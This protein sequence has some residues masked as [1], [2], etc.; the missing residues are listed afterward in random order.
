MRAVQILLFPTMLLLLTAALAQTAATTPWQTVTTSDGSM[1]QARHES[2]AV[3]V[4]GKLY[5]L[6]GRAIRNIQEFDPATEVWT[7]L[8]P[9]PLELHHFQPVAIDQFIYVIA[10]FTCCYPM[11]TLVPEIHVFDTQTLTWSVEGSMPASR[12]RGSA[13]SVVRDGII[14]IVGGN[15]LGHSGGAVNWFDKYDPVTGEWTELPDAPNA[16]DHFAAVLVNDY[17]VAAAGRQTDLPNPFNY[18][19]LPTDVFDFITGEWHT[20]DPIPTPR[21]GVL[22]AAAGDE[23]LIAGGEINTSASALATVE[24]FNVYSGKWRTLEPLGIARHSGG[25]AVI[26]QQF[27]VLAGSMNAGGAPE[28]SAHE[29][30]EID[31]NQSIDFDADGLS[32]VAERAVYGTNP[33][34]ADTDFD[35]LSDQDEITEHGSDPLKS[36]TDDDG[37]ADGDEVNAWGTDPTD[38]DTDGDTLSDF[39][40]VFELSTN[41]MLADTDGDLLD[42]HIEINVH[43]T[44]PANTDTDADGIGDGQEVQS[45]LNPLDADSDNDGIPDGQDEEPLIGDAPTETETPTETEVPAETETPTETEV[46]T[47]TE[48]EPTPEVDIPI[49]SG[50]SSGGKVSILLLAALLVGR[51]SRIRLRRVNVTAKL[52][53]I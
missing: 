30:L 13:A 50:N 49:S 7:D 32:N 2:G 15:T 4:N 12:V 1:A 43:Q 27:H 35:N 52:F 9:L 25:G 33:G 16:R 22:A 45:G 31:E 37:I 23:V 18:A 36:D 40:E 14:Y 41:P 34:R 8:G 42:D 28:T 26:N 11:E 51:L 48:E 39:E 3:T 53:N 17:L 38:P 24:A 5:L 47:E 29:Y 44:D 46:P 6:G 10:G 19:V 20:T 21:A